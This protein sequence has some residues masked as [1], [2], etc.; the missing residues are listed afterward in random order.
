MKTPK[1]VRRLTYDDNKPN[2]KKVYTHKLYYYD[3]KVVQTMKIAYGQFQQE[4]YE[5][6]GFG[7]IDWVDFD[8]ALELNQDPNDN[9]P[10]FL[11]THRHSCGYCKSN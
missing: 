11:F 3:F 6:D 4:V 8:K 10:I 1:E 5:Q 9:R 2:K 7:P